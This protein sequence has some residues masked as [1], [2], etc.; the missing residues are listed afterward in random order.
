MKTT[1]SIQNAQRACHTFQ[2]PVVTAQNGRKSIFGLAGEEI[3]QVEKTAVK[4]HF[5]AS[6]DGLAYR[7]WKGTPERRLQVP[8]AA[9]GRKEKVPT[10]ARDKSRAV[11]WKVT[12]MP[13]SGRDGM[14]MCH[15]FTTA[16]RVL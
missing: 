14:R 5:T 15:R 9:G 13:P 6:G 12:G 3:T 4:I 7:L 11:N 2:S 8:E 1:F 10:T 16:A